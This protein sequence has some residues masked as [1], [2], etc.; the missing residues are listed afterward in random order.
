MSVIIPTSSPVC[1]THD[2]ARATVMYDCPEND[3]HSNLPFN[4]VVVAVVVAVV[5]T[6]LVAVVTSVDVAVVVGVDSVHPANVPSWND[7]IAPFSTGTTSP[8][9]TSTFKIPLAVHPMT[10]STV[11]RLYRCTPRSN[12]RAKAGQPPDATKKS[13]A[14]GWNCA[15]PKTEQSARGVGAPPHC[16]ASAVSAAA[17]LPQ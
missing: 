6:V 9:P 17:V 10:C 3:A 13:D 4:E 7:S 16:S 8:H 14:G 11:P 12:V 15:D 2:S 1:R 5:L